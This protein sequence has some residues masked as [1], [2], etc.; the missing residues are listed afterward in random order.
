[1]AALYQRYAFDHFAPGQSV[2]QD[3]ALEFF[4]HDLASPFIRWSR[5]EP[6]GNAS[7]ISTQLRPGDLDPRSVETGGDVCSLLDDQ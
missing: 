3:S 7:R 5:N 4:L 6:C 2:E 1:M